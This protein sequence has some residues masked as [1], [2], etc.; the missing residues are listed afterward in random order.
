MERAQTVG[1]DRRDKRAV[2]DGER[3]AE[4]REYRETWEDQGRQSSRKKYKQRKHDGDSERLPAV[5]N[6]V[7]DLAKDVSLG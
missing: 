7:Y 5:E 4:S 3:E 2:E 6:E 1:D